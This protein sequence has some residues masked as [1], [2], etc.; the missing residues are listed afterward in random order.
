MRPALGATRR[1]IAPRRS[2]LVPEVLDHLAVA[3]LGA[4]GA[5]RDDLEPLGAALEPARDSGRDADHIP[6]AQV[7]DLVVELDL[8][9]AADDDVRLL[10]LAVAVAERGPVARAVAEVADPE[11]LGVECACARSA[12]RC[13]AP[14]SAAESS[15]SLRFLIVKS[16]MPQSMTRSP[17]RPRSDRRR[18]ARVAAWANERSTHQG[19]SAGPT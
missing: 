15:R 9:R 16:G 12:P 4:V 1:L 7:D 17:D 6:R 13:P 5:D 3:A 11:V 14:R 19:P 2:A 8:P 18:G 10:L